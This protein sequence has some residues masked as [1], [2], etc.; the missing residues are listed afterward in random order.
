VTGTVGAP[1][2][3][4]ARA[5]DGPVGDRLAGDPA[6]AIA[7]AAALLARADDVTL[8]AHVR[9]DAD[10]L[11]SALALGRVLQRRGTRV[12]VSFGAPDTVPETLRPL[13]VHRLVV[14]AS[15]VPPAPPVLVTC[16]VN[17]PARLGPLA[18]RLDTAGVTVML[19]HHVTNPG[20]GDVRILAPRVEATVMLVRELLRAMDEALDHDVA[21]CLYAGLVTDT[22]NFRDAGPAA[23]RLAAEL[24]EAG[25]DPHTL[26]TPIMDTHPFPWLAVLA[27]LL[28]SAELDPTAAHGLGMVHTVI[29]AEHVARFR[30]EEVD[31]VVDTLRTAA[32]AEVAAVMKQVGP[33]RWTVSLRARGR[34]NVA[35][36]AAALGGG[37][38]PR[39]A[40]VT[41]DGTA[42]EVVAAVRAAL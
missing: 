6:R 15:Q 10:A 37:G 18:D 13:D 2:A 28:Q 35:A 23:H 12:R 38:H 22:R 27:D 41:L 9:P 26:V 19:D 31:G 40:G 29:P 34:V 4:E 24:I 11:G 14:P 20:F 42:G 16:D 21:R 1:P 30:Q 36:A 5:S 33:A 7:V 25:A 32:E 39:A 3:R 8:L 17:E